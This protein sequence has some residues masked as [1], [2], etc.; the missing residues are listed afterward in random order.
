M[1]V[2][3][4]LAHP[5]PHLI[6]E[7]V[8]ALAPDRRSLPTSCPVASV[9]AVRVLVN[10]SFFVPS[11]GLY[12][13]ATLTASVRGPYRV[14][15]CDRTLT[16]TTSTVTTTIDLAPG[17]DGLV[18]PESIA[19]TL[20]AALSAASVGVVDGKLSVTDLGSV[21][22]SSF[23]QVSGSGAPW[24]GFKVQ[25]GAVGRTVYPGWE[26]I[27]EP[28]SVLG[29]YPVFREPLRNNAS[30]KV[31][32][33]TYPVRCR[34][35]GGSFVE[36]DWEYN[37]QGNTLMV[38]NE[39]LL[40][41]ESLKIIL[42]RMGSNAYFPTYGTGIVDSIGKKAVSTT[43]SDIKTQVR[44]ALRVVTLSQQAQSKFQQLTL[45]ERLYTVNSVDVTQSGDDPTVFLVDV[46]V[47][48]ASAKPVR[49]SIVY[50]APGAVALAGTNGLSLGT[51]AVGLR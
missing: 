50:T 21:G 13:P 35:C 27:G 15:V 40:V 6:L 41:Q 39:D 28:S 48:N 19:R 9:N 17:A 34:R 36:N 23:V 42:T 20:T 16:V 24:V 33:S 8:V 37:L 44:E 25:R 29:R 7:E 46:T 26:I 38:A 14:P 18:H 2:D 3:I 11:T 51:Q 1:S 22:L 49:V 4:R 45:E 30:F 31:S 10:D 47:T 12:D 43:A 32:Y 5:C